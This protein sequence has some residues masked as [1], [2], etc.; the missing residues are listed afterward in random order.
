MYEPVILR[1]AKLKT[2]AFLAKPCYAV[3][4][5][6]FPIIKFFEKTGFLLNIPHFAAFS[7]VVALSFAVGFVAQYAVNFIFSHFLLYLKYD[8]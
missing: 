4:L 3:Y 8:R 7:L 6:H 5:L 1:F 2:I